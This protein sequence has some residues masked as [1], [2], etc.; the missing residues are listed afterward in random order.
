MLR[1]GG[2]ERWARTS[3][4]RD[5]WSETLSC[6]GQCTLPQRLHL[7]VVEKMNKKEINFEDKHN[8]VRGDEHQ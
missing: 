2:K 3:S 8:K 7:R 5:L 1:L 4:W 6:L